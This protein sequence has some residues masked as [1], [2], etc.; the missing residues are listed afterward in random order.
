MTIAELWDDPAVE[1]GF[2]CDVCSKFYP[3]EL[4]GELSNKSNIDQLICI[5]CAW[6]MKENNNG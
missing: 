6:A 5:D 4:C 2:I 1:T 3:P